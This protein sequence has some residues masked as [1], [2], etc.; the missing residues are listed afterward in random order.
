MPSE[1]LFTPPHTECPEPELWSAPDDASS[2]DEVTAFLLALTHLLKPQTIVETGAFLGFT[3]AALAAALRE[4]GRRHVFSVE[5]DAG[6]AAKAQDRLAERAL[7]DWATVVNASSLEWSPPQP[8][9]LAFLDAGGGWHRAAEFLHLRPHMHAGTVVAVHD[10]AA[11]NRF[12]RL[13]FEALAVRGLLH[14][15]YMRTP[16]GLLVAQPRW[17]TPP[18]QLAGLPAYAVYRAYAGARLTTSDVRS[19]LATRRGR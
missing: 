6:N 13:S 10:T 12:P 15:V 3:T 17:P 2:E 5:L 8:V 1:A 18:R 14:P 19:R 16:R 7:D 11:K 4:N 9:D